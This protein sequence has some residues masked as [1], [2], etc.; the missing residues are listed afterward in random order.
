MPVIRTLD[1]GTIL[2]YDTGKF[3]KWCVYVTRVGG[4]RIAP[5]DVQYFEEIKNLCRNY[6]NTKVYRDLTTIFNMVG[7]SI[8]TTHFTVINTIAQTYDV[9]DRNNVEIMLCT[10]YMAMISEEN[11]AYSRLGKRIKMLGIYQVIYENMR[12]WD[13]ANYSKG[14]KWQGL[15]E[16][17]EERGF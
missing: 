14:R 6:G 15:A 1:D 2:E 3:D 4:V 11:K 9:T 13:A 12:P 10:I 7:R 17:C 8:D 5:R 16:E